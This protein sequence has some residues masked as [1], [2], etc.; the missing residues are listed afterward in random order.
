MNV[1]VPIYHQPNQF[2]DDSS[3]MP[4]I[5]II[6]WTI[7]AMVAVGVVVMFAKCLLSRRHPPCPPCPP[8]PRPTTSGPPMEE[9]L[10]PEP[11]YP[12]YPEPIGVA[13]PGPLPPGPPPP[14]AYDPDLEQGSISERADRTTESSKVGNQPRVPPPPYYRRC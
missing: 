14:Q 3:A 12:L 13:P 2:D 10:Y 4:I 8:C 9:P 11:R 6:I 7:V 5:D 1:P